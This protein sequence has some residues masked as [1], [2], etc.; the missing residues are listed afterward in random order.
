MIPMLQ[1]PSPQLSQPVT[2]PAPV[3]GV[4][5]VDGYAEMGPQDSIYTYNMYSGPGGLRVRGGYSEWQ[6]SVGSLNG[7]RTLIPYT[8]SVVAEDSLFATSKQG[9]YDISASGTNPT[10]ALTFAT[11]DSNSGYGQYIGYATIG[12]HFLLYCDETNGYIYYGEGTGTWTVA[13]AGITGVTATTLVSVCVHKERVWFVE[14]GT[15]NAWYLPVGQILGAATKFNFG[16]RFRK[17]GY[18]VNLYSWTVDGGNGVDDYL[19]AISSSG[20]VVVFRGNDPNTSTDWFEQGSWFIGKP[21]AGRRVAG[22]FGGE[23]YLLSGYGVLP[24]SKLLSGALVQDENTAVSRRITPFIQEQMQT[25]TGELGWE[26][27]LI[28]SENLLLVSTPLITGNTKL[29]FVQSLNKQAWSMFRDLPYFT[30]VEWDGQFYFSDGVGTVYVLS[31]Y[32]DGVLLNGTGAAEVEFSLLTSFQDIHPPGAFKR[33]QFIRPSFLAQGV[34]GYEVAA[35]Y[36]YDLDETDPVVAGSIAAGAL[37]DSAVWDGA[38]WGGGFT[39]TQVTNGGSGIGRAIAVAL[40]GKTS[41]KTTLVK[42]EVIHDGGGLL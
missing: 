29:Q 14:R 30:G 16:S 6:T 12:G 13:G 32:S 34:P 28:T 25:L 40:R 4:N 36:D 15:A 39:V 26:V 24:I 3:L 22:S 9:I 38:V 42:L 1:R 31:G 19:V 8:G 21:P 20:D 33:V 41:V 37:W 2:I 11:A 35:R 10:A 18:L 27:Q 17:G 5:A 23:L 7:G